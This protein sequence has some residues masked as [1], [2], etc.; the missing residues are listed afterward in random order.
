ME[1]LK[2]IKKIF[3]KPEYLFI[4]FF[5]KMEN[6]WIKIFKY[7]LIFLEYPTGIYIYIFL[8]KMVNNR[9]KYIETTKRFLAYVVQQNSVVQDV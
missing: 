6:T 2:K 7:F 5:I 4:I 1:Y 8:I 3:E 9:I